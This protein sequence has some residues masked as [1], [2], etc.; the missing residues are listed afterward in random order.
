MKGNLI[1]KNYLIIFLSFLFLVVSCGVTSSVT[2]LNNSGNTGLKIQCTETP[3]LVYGPVVFNRHTPPQTETQTFTL[4][5]IEGTYTINLQNGDTNGDCRVSSAT[6]SI[7]DEDI[8]T[9]NDFNQQVEKLSKTIILKTENTINVRITSQPCSFITI[10]IVKEPTPEVTPTPEPT[11]EPTTEPTVVPTPEPTVEPTPE[12]TVVP[13]PEP[14]VE[15]TPE[16]TSIPVPDPT[17]TP[18]QKPVIGTL[19]ANPNPVT[20]AG[21][22]AAIKVNVSDTETPVENL[23]LTW[24]ATEN[25]TEMAAGT[26]SNT[27][28]IGSTLYVVWTSPIIDITKSYLITLTVND[29]T[30]TVTSTPLLITVLGGTGTG[31][32]QGGYN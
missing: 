7:N 5:N 4:Q 12:P 22:P 25:G 11:V 27:R 30:D 10:N 29:G 13:T 32:A 15:P 28:I 31:V 20:G 23:T 14:T 6:I 18:N 19:D 8:F 26:F 17:P 16:P 1:P 2:S 9:P 21:Y 3:E 24:S